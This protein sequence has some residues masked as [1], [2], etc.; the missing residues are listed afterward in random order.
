MPTVTAASVEALTGLPALTQLLNATRTDSDECTVCAP[1]VN[2]ESV[3]VVRGRIV[4]TNVG[5]PRLAVAFT[6]AI[7]YD[8]I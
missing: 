7:M 8:W 4:H 2:Q 5:K 1:A 6:I 3:E